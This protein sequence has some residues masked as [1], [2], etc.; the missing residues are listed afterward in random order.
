M[1]MP[2]PVN[3]PIHA[4][5]V[6]MSAMAHHHV[7]HA[8]EHHATHPT[9]QPA[10]KH[11]HGD[12]ACCLAGQNCTMACN[13]TLIVVGDNSIRR[14]VHIAPLAHPSAQPLTRAPQPPR[15]PPKA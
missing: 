13:I 8:A 6:E 11:H 3:T 10:T 14:G 12:G 4:K 1:A 15:R 2:S 5:P 9:S 7:D